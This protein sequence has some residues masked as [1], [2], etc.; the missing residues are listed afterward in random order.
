M[1]LKI[2]LILCHIYTHIIRTPLPT[3]LCLGSALHVTINAIEHMSQVKGCVA[4]NNKMVT[5]NE[6]ERLTLEQY[7]HLLLRDK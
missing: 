2:I 7:T 4:E 6:V 3:Y 1:A 5:I